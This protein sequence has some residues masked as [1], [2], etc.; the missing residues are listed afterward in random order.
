[1]DSDLIVIV[2]GAVLP[3]YSALFVIYQK[4]GKYNVMSENLGKLRKEHGRILQG[5]RHVPTARADH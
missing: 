2:L 5:D 3:I 1:M 4:I